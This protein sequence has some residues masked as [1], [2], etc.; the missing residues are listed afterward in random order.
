MTHW[1]FVTGGGGDIGGAICQAM[2]RD[3]WAIACVDRAMD[4]AEAVAALVRQAGGQAVAIEADVTDPASV[5]AAVGQAR[6]LGE[7]RALVNTAGKAHAITLGVT[8]AASWRAD[9]SVNL[10]SA[11]LCIQALKGVL[12]AEGGV[13]VNIASVNG[14][15]VYGF[16]G[17][18]A[19]KAALIHLSQS[20]AVEFG[21]ANVR[22]NVVAPGTVRTRAWAA[23]LEANPGLFDELKSLCPLQRISDPADVAEAVV[24][25]ASKRASMITG[26]VLAVDGGLSTGVAAVGQAVTQE[27][28]R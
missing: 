17:Y 4:R 12:M 11:F 2:A 20:M 26:A 23:R 22:V 8:D 27:R 16:P 19:A 24:F 13:I 5:A 10:D 3:G 9:F 15:G 6:A 28:H 1:A 25:L 18:S 21:P 14:I 7:I